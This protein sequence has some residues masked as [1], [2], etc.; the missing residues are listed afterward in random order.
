MFDK[1][2]TNKLLLTY[3][4]PGL[5]VP[6]EYQETMLQNNVMHFQNKLIHSNQPGKQKQNNF[7]I[8]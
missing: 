7:H 5:S 3:L 2:K 8:Q 1:K 6:V 4:G